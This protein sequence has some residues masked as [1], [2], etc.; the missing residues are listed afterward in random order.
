VS[1]IKLIKKYPGAE[2]R[3]KA[4]YWPLAA[5]IAMLVTFAL[6]LPLSYDESFTFNEFT[7][8]D[9][10]TSISNYPVP[11]NHVF[12]S[13]LTNITW[14]IFSFTRSEMAVRLPALL[15]TALSLYFIYTRFFY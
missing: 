12:H 3:N 6:T 15:F 10:L 9:I 5:I 11:N 8:K 13:I 2:K 4:V 7:S 1:G 14:A